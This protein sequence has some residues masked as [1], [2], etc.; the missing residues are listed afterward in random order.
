MHID[1]VGH[2]VLN[3]RDL[4]KSVPFYRDVLGLREVGRYGSK[5]VFFTATGENHHDLG[6]FEI[7]KD[8]DPADEH[9]VGI[10]H[11]AF[12]I[13]VGLETLRA[14]K[15]HLKKH[16]VPIRRIE[17]HTV[18]QSIYIGDPDGIEIELT[19]DDDPKKWAE[20]PS[21]VA[22]VAPLDL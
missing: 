17:D 9:A 7:E 16:G 3:V 15:E 22:S 12:R 21:A 18:S 8:A 13:G 2:V 19:V 11:V 5:M 14:A 10:A 1:R 4:E 6:I 20:D